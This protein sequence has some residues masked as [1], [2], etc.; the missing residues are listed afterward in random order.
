MV[1]PNIVNVLISVA[2][3]LGLWILFHWQYASYRQ[4]LLQT[5]IFSLRQELFDLGRAGKVSFDHPA[6]GVLRTTMNG[7]VKV[8]PRFNLV[9]LILFFLMFKEE[10]KGRE[11]FV[12]RLERLSSDLPE[13]VRG[14]LKALV[15][16]LD[17][18]VLCHLLFTSLPFAVLLWPAVAGARCLSRLND[19]RPL[20][21]L[22]L[23]GMNNAAL[24]IG[25]EGGRLDPAY[26]CAP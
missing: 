4:D 20:R 12:A 16:E 21:Y 26:A 8:S 17:D 3:L 15:D 2:A 1:E 23:S 13:E 5:R 10:L 7:Y 14:D 25:S 11:D 18:V 22:K 19:Y 6:Y 24:A 9:G